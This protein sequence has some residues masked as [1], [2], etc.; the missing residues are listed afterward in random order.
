MATADPPSEQLVVGEEARAQRA[1][2][3][4]ARARQGGQFLE[5]VGRGPHHHDAGRRLAGKVGA[6]LYVPR[7][8]DAPTVTAAPAVPPAEG[9]GTVIGLPLLDAMVP[10]LGWAEVMVVGPR[11]NPP[12]YSG[13]IGAVAREEGGAPV[14]VE[15]ELRLA[16]DPDQNRDAL[17]AREQRSSQPPSSP[18][19][20]TYL[21]AA[22]SQPSLV[23]LFWSD[24]QY[25]PHNIAG[26]DRSQSHCAYPRS[27]G[28]DQSPNLEPSDCPVD[29]QSTPGVYLQA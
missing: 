13:G 19:W 5:L 29:M 25:F 12:G 1:E 14:L 27:P 23:S 28:T 6:C 17:A 8:A 10:A 9:A 11:F 18:L 21:P 4:H 24:V 15:G 22:P 3:A 7:P 16:H 26:W 2:R 20:A